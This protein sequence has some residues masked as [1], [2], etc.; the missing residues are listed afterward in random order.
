M[1]TILNNLVYR[2]SMNT[3]ILAIVG[4]NINLIISDRINFM[5]PYDFLK[6]SIRRK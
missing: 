3:I 4:V 2:E 1:F 6:L 5:W